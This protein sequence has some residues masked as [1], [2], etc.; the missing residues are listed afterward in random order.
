[1][2]QEVTFTRTKFCEVNINNFFEFLSQFFFEL[3]GQLKLALV[4]TSCSDII[5]MSY[6]SKFSKNNAMEALKV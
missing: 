2:S 3:L 1:M 6:F 5:T 4:M